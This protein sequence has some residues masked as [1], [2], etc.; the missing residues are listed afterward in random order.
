[1]DGSKVLFVSGVDV[2]H[3]VGEEDTPRHQ[4]DYQ[5]F[6]AAIHPVVL[7]VSHISA[8]RNPTVKLVSRHLGN[9]WGVALAAWPRVRRHKVVIATGE[10]V[11]F[12]LAFL[13][14]LSHQKIPLI[15]TCHNVASRRPGFY[16]KYLHVANKVSL[17]QCLSHSQA[18]LLSGYPGVTQDQIQLLYWHVD[19]DFFAPMPEIP[20]ENQICSAGMA[21]RDYAT[22]V[23]AVEGMDISLKIAADSP[24]FRQKLNICPESLPPNME[25][26]SYQTYSA[27]RALYASSRFVVVPLLDVPYSAG[28]TVILEAM[29]MG[30]AVIVSRIKQKDDFVVDG[31]NGLYVASGNAAD[32]REKIHYLLQRPDEASRLGANARKTV[33]DRY[34]LRHYVERCKAGMLC[35]TGASDEH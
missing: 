10:D 16:L 1:L 32:L 12:P 23:A 26:R 27:L 31:W 19:H 33:E 34:T 3:P 29:A 17:F 11:G 20:V 6:F 14:K 15:V 21:S 2:S 8:T 4:K 30:K 5:A 13:L 7:D 18:G 28:Y 22:L 35:A 9:A 25:V 24:W